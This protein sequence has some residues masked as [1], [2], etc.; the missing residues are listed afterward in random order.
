MQRIVG[1][2]TLL[3]DS[4]TRKVLNEAAKLASAYSI[5]FVAN[6]KPFGSGTLLSINGIKG[7]L[8]AHHVVHELYRFMDEQ[9][10]LCYRNSAPHRPDFNRA[11]FPFITVGDSSK[12]THQH[13]GPDMAFMVLLDPNWSMLLNG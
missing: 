2:S 13:L 10:S 6:Q 5:I 4:A 7:I 3:P 1:Q 11:L 12:L 9:I 8:T